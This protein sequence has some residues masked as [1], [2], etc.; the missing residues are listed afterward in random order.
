MPRAL[1]SKVTFGKKDFQ[2][3]FKVII[4]IV[5]LKAQCLKPLWTHTILLGKLFATSDGSGSKSTRVRAGS[6]SY[7]LRVKSISGSGQGP[8]LFATHHSHCPHDAFLS[9]DWNV[10]IPLMPLT[11]SWLDDS[12]LH[13]LVFDCWK[14]TDAQS[15]SYFHPVYTLL[16]DL[17]KDV[18][19][20]HDSLG[21]HFRF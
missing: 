7:L 9:D 21:H 16:I 19:L 13:F 10:R 12:S 6:A 11:V 15:L 14:L 20:L 4:G 3:T 8:S 18:E 1:R 5:W 2:I 17:L